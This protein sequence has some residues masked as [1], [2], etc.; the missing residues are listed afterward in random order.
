MEFRNSYEILWN[1]ESKENCPVE[2][3]IVLFRDSW[4]F[5][6]N[7][8][9]ELYE[10]ERITTNLVESIKGC[11]ESNSD[12]SELEKWHSSIFDEI[13]MKIHQFMI[14]KFQKDLDKFTILW[15]NDSEGFE[16]L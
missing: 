3:F 7:Y 4:K 10:K 15:S 2:T 5:R 6:L 14:E 13:L 11:F 16:G 9:R 1:I 8:N 12:I